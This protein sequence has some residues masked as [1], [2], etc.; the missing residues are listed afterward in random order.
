MP[1]VIPITAAAH[2]RFAYGRSKACQ[3]VCQSHHIDPCPPGTC[4]LADART[5][6]QCALLAAAQI[7]RRERE[8]DPRLHTG[9]IA[10]GQRPAPAHAPHPEAVDPCGNEPARLG[11]LP[12]PRPLPSV[13]ADPVPTHLLALAIAALLLIVAAVAI[14]SGLG[15]LI[16]WAKGA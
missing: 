10:H 4:D 14:G 3:G 8:L 9:E 2:R 6:A 12:P 5:E 13:S 16:G 15:E 7:H 11:S 1:Q